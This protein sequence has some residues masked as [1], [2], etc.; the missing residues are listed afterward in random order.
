MCCEND[1]EWIDDA[2]LHLLQKSPWLRF[3]DL[4]AVLLTDTVEKI[5]SLQQQNKI[6]EY[7][8]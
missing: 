2:V 7:R 6:R 3:L 4:Q 5:C 1:S 8:V